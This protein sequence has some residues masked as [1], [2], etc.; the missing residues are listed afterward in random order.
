MIGAKI[1]SVV[2][3]AWVGLLLGL[4]GVG[5]CAFPAPQ[6]PAWELPPPP[7]PEN[8]VV[9]PG[10]LHRAE[11]ENGLQ[12][13]VLEDPRLPRVSFAL[14][15]R[16]GE[17]I[18]PASQAG[19]AFFTAELLRRGAG[20]RDAPAFAA[21]VDRLGASAGA[22]AGWDTIG[23]SASG[24]SR[25]LDFLVEI[26]ADMVL[27]PRFD[28][29][30]ADRARSEILQSLERAKDDPA[31]LQRWYGARTLYEGHRFGLPM[32]G[33]PETVAALD[34]KAARDFHARV[35]LPNDAIL[36]VSGDVDAA[37]V[38]GTLRRVFGGWERGETV[39]YGAPPPPRVP[40]AQKLVIVDR[41]DLVQTRIF[42]GHEGIERTAE[43]RVAAQLLNSVVGGSGFSSRL[44]E[45]LRTET[46]LTYSVHSGFSMRRAPGPFGVS[47]FTA[48]ANAGIALEAVLAELERGREEPPGEDEL[49]W[50]RTLAAGR[51]SMALETSGAVMA[52][53]V[54]LDVYGLPRDSLD[55]YRSRVRAATAA[56]V[57]EAARRRLHPE[58]LA[59]VLVGPAEALV[60]Q[61]EAFGP[62]EI[63]TP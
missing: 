47:T 41:P 38:L 35:F 31:T 56:D 33:S 63:V 32:S 14:T 8:P 50:A 26:L 40:E 53:L 46:G 5:G 12:V 11:L 52:A 49:S 17:A 24:L 60:P 1:C 19:R 7:P 44:M 16:R 2:A 36:S 6:R 22:A 42:V 29:A 48:V 34:A 10:R 20:E 15:L 28:P 54:D 57:S 39:P 61:L 18:L 37:E 21:A 3:V 13:I 27:R 45:S 58:R 9:Q 4:V 59:I 23:V 55:T 43:D 62:I 30:E 25:D 51:F